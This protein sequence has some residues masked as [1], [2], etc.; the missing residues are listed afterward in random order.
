MKDFVCNSTEDIY[1]LSQICING[2]NTNN[3]ECVK[4]YNTTISV[5]RKGIGVW[6][7]LVAVLGTLGNLMTLI[8]IPQ[9]ARYKRHNLDKHFNT[10]TIF[11]LHLAFIDLSHCVLFIWPQVVFNLFDSSPFGSWGCKIIDISGITTIGADMLALALIAVSRCIGMTWQLKWNQFCDRKR[12]IFLL[13]FVV[14]WVPNIF[15]P[16][17]LYYIKTN[18]FEPGWNC[19]YGGCSFIQ[20][21]QIEEVPQMQ[22]RLHVHENLQNQFDIICN[23]NALN[24]VYIYTVGVPVAAILIIIVSYLCIW[25][26]VHDSSKNF[27]DSDHNTAALHHREMKMSLTIL[28]LIVLTFVLWLPL[29]LAHLFIF[30]FHTRFSASS[31]TE[32]TCFVILFSIFESRFAV[33]FFFYA[34]RSEHYRNSFLDTFKLFSFP[35]RNQHQITLESKQQRSRVQ[36][37]TEFELEKT[38]LDNNR[39]SL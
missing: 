29:S 14:C 37:V 20:H 38:R 6:F 21:C 39:I 9:A 28:I 33:N 31:G 18:G 32:Y 5:I 13:M 16:V 23:F 36:S 17:V 4:F 1:W 12:N 25:N 8:A 24:L 19:E 11:I 3:Y 26:R 34:A 2:S 30:D 10:S 22:Y 35:I 27:K 15:C 7:L